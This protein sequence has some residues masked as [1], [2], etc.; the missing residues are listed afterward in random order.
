MNNNGLNHSVR[1]SNSDLLKMESLKVEHKFQ[2]NTEI[3]FNDKLIKLYQEYEI[4]YSF[5]YLEI[6][7]IFLE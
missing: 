1:I 4:E 5:E 3:L 2:H 6:K 7:I